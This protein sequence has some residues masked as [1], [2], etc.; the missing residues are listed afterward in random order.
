MF[1]LSDIILSM[2]AN[3]RG[4]VLVI[5]EI[6]PTYPSSPEQLGITTAQMVLVMNGTDPTSCCV[7]HSAPARLEWLEW[8]RSEELIA[9]KH[10][11]FGRYPLEENRI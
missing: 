3:I 11:R 1:S 6:C 8:P 2:L 10:N 4:S 5:A 9:G 7:M